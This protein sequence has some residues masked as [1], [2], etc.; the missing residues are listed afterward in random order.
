[1]NLIQWRVVL[2]DLE[3]EVASLKRANLALTREVETWKRNGRDFE[4]RALSSEAA[5][6]FAQAESGRL[7]SELTEAKRKR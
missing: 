4:R 7:R 3:A 2:A 1:M 6:R 5:R